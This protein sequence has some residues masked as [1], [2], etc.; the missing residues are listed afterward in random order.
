MTDSVFTET[1]KELLRADRVSP[2]ILSLVDPASRLSGAVVEC[3]GGW[4]ALMRWQR[5]AGIV[6]GDDGAAIDT[7]ALEAALADF[8][9]GFDLP[10]S[11][12]DSLGA[13]IGEARTLYRSRPFGEPG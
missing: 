10:A 13:A 9:G 8:T 11:T 7:A 4:A 3:G 12:A 2:F 6:L 5:A 1:M